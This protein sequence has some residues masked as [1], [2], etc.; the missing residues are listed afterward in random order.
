LGGYET[1]KFALR[2]LWDAL[3]IIHKFWGFSGGIDKE[4]VFYDESTKKVTILNWDRG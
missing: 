4:G 3:P 2:K 1:V